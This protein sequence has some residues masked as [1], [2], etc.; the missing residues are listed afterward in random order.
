MSRKKLKDHASSSLLRHRK[1]CLQIYHRNR[2]NRTDVLAVALANRISD[3]TRDIHRT[4]CPVIDIHN[5]NPFPKKK[6]SILHSKKLHF[7]SKASMIGIQLYKCQ[8]VRAMTESV[9]KRERGSRWYSKGIG[10]VHQALKIAFP[11]HNVE[12]KLLACFRGSNA[13]EYHGDQ[14]KWMQLWESISLK[15][16]SLDMLHSELNRNMCP[17]SAFLS[18]EPHTSF[19]VGSGVDWKSSP[20]SVVDPHIHDIPVGTLTVISGS[21]VH[22]G[23]PFPKAL[24]YA[25][26]IYRV[27]FM[28][29]PQ[30]RYNHGSESQMFISASRRKY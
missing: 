20:P 24:R 22:A 26:A 11:Y 10:L 9:H 16:Q 17:C 7:P 2:T 4:E 30:R 12:C 28:I 13:Q 1:K 18:I 8:K 23:G 15:T 6:R 27:F 25:D 21:T 5:A 19:L 14:D 29:D 3:S